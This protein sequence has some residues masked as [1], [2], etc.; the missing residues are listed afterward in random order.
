M[1]S[2]ET[3]YD[4]AYAAGFRGADADRA[5]AIALAESGG[6][7]D[8]TA[9]TSAEYSVG[10]MQINLKAGHGISEADARDPYKAMAYSFGLVMDTPQ[11]WDHWSV[12][13]NGSYQQFMPG[14]IDEGYDTTRHNPIAGGSGM[15]D[16]LGEEESGGNPFRL[17]ELPGLSANQADGRYYKNGRPATQGEIDAAIAIKYPNGSPDGISAADILQ[18]A[19]QRRGQ[20]ISARGQDIDAATSMR[21]QD[22]SAASSRYGNDLAYASQAQDRAQQAYQFDQTQ[23]LA[24]EQWLF[25]KENKIQQLAIQRE[26]LATQQAQNAREFVIAQQNLQLQKDKFG[27]ESAMSLR[28]ESRATEAQMFQQ[29]SVVAGLQME[30]VAIAQR[31]KELNAQ[32]QQEVNI[33]NAGKA[34]DVSMF[35]I[36]QQTKAAMFNSEGAMKAGMFNAEMQF[37]VDKANT[38]NER[39]RQE[40]LQRLADSISEAAKDPGD[41]GKLA[42]L[43]LANSGFGAMDAAI[44]MY[45]GTTPDSLMPLE[46]LLRQREDVMESEARPFKTTPVTFTPVTAGVASFTPAKAVQASAPD[47]SGVKLPTPNT[48]P[49]NPNSIPTSA[50]KPAPTADSTK[51][52]FIASGNTTAPGGEQFKNQAGTANLTAEQRAQMP[53]FVIDDMIRRGQL[54]AMAEGGKVRG[55]YIG[56]ERGPEMHIPFGNGDRMVIPANQTR[57]MADQA[58]QHTNQSGS[59]LPGG[60]MN[61]GAANSGP[62]IPVMP[63]QNDWQN[64]PMYQ[65]AME[66]FQNVRNMG[67]NVQSNVQQNVQQQTNQTGQLPAGFLESLRGRLPFNMPQMEEGGIVEGAYIGNDDGDAVHIP[68]PGTAMTI[69]MPKGK[70]K[71]SKGMKKMATGGLFVNEGKS[72]YEGLLSDTDRTRAQNFLGEASKRASFGTPFDIDRLQTPVFASSPGTSRFVSDLLGSLNSIKRGLPPE[73]FEEQRRLLTPTAFSEGVIGRTR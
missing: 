57:Q 43:I 73:Y 41:R 10:P 64:N 24:K 11:G 26:T 42:S 33:F 34:A 31:T 19:T 48:T 2:I 20:D 7:E 53:Q 50:P 13:A 4:A 17:G 15:P 68:I 27:F 16:P 12:Y 59:F 21:G 36:D 38:E 55:A 69:I 37:N 62:S 30:Q 70:G 71:K 72:M 40:Q 44:A 32:L 14:G 23:A 39:L 54:P 28:Q 65:R 35:N 25:E 18:D 5:V 49:F 22:I 66:M 47:F 56:D 1:A 58:V 6:R 67:N 60:L 46:A 29:Q 61:R 3:L 8:A 52:N 45:D 51:Q 63:E 9:N